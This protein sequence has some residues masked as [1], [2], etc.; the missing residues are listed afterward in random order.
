MSDDDV[1]TPEEME[2]VLRSAARAITALDALGPSPAREETQQEFEAALYGALAG[3]SPEV[4]QEEFEAALGGMWVIH[5]GEGTFDIGLSAV[6]PLA[7]SLVCWI[8]HLIENDHVVAHFLRYRFMT[9]ALMIPVLE[10]LD[11]YALTRPEVA[12]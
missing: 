1:T 6:D 2:A 3:P 7:L 8:A 11:F 5:R 9:G 10:V 4:S 12:P